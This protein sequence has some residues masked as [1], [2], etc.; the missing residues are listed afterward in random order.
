MDLSVRLLLRE[1]YCH[2]VLL[3]RTALVAGAQTAKLAAGLFPIS[4]VWWRYKK[5][6]PSLVGVCL[7][8]PRHYI[9]FTS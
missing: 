4:L 7:A 2:S 8:A 6:E 3:E 5:A 9:T 1:D